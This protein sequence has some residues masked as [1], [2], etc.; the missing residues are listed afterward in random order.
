[1]TSKIFSRRLAAMTS[2]SLDVDAPTAPPTSDKK[3][4][5]R[6]RATGLKLLAEA[7]C[8][9]GC[10]EEAA[11]SEWAPSNLVVA[12]GCRREG[13]VSREGSQDAPSMSLSHS[14]VLVTHP[15]FSGTEGKQPPVPSSNGCLRG[16]IT[17]R[18]LPCIPKQSDTYPSWRGE[19]LGTQVADRVCKGSQERFGEGSERLASSANR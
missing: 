3:W 11:R 7:K 8:T 5:R 17:P 6:R 12:N 19:G 4:T 16:Q 9:D 18:A 13:T 10:C 14:G 15:L 2:S 1:M